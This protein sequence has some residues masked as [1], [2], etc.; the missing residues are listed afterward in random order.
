MSDPAEFKVGDVVQL[1]SGGPHMVVVEVARDAIRCCWFTDDQTIE[2]ASFD[3]RTVSRI[4][5]LL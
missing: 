3:P 5:N 2:S 1:K 4:G